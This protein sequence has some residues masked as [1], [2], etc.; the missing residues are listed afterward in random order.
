[1]A[2][3][4]GT[5]KPVLAQSTPNSNAFVSHLLTLYSQSRHSNAGT[6]GMDAWGESVYVDT[7]LDRA[8]WPTWSSQV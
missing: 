2:T 8:L 1:M 3:A 7:A 6:R 4:V 5:G